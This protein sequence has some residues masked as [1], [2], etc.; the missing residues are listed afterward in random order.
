MGSHDFKRLGGSILY[1]SSTVTSPFRMSVHA[2][3]LVED[4]A[5][6]P[7]CAAPASW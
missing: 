1:I 2:I 6:L 5:S 4:L 7:L 3:L